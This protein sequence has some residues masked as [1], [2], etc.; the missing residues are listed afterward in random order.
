MCLGREILL[1]FQ[2]ETSDFFTIV[3]STGREENISKLIRS[4]F[5]KT[6]S[7]LYTFEILHFTNLLG[8][9][10][11]VLNKFQFYSLY[12]ISR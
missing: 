1:Q 6:Y 4:C 11:R 5:D 8:K 9:I 10:I 2:S 7:K 12:I 3:I